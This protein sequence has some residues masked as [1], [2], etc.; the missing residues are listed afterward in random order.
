[1][2]IP[3]RHPKIKWEL[4]W[5]GFLCLFFSLSFP[6]SNIRPMNSLLIVPI[7][8][9]EVDFSL[10]H[11]KIYSLCGMENWYEI[12]WTNVE[13]PLLNGQFRR[14]T[15]KTRNFHL[16]LN[17]FLFRKCDDEA[18]QRIHQFYIEF[19]SPRSE[20]NFCSNNTRVL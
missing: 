18:F 11:P 3:H 13:I 4:N 7:V 12:H 10:T 14:S 20:W 9:F 16:P 17:F 2:Q 15:S 1:M 6:L 5:W 19:P 8:I